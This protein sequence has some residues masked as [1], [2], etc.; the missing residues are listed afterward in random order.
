MVGT[1]EMAV[2]SPSARRSKLAGST[3]ANA[4]ASPAGTMP[5]RACARARAPS[6]SSI[7]ASHAW[8]EK[9]A[10]IASVA[11][12]GPSSSESSDEKA[13]CD[14]LMMPV[15]NPYE[16]G[17]VSR[18]GQ[19]NEARPNDK[20][21][22]RHHTT[23]VS[24]KV[25]RLQCRRYRDE[26]ALVCSVDCAANVR[27]EAC[28]NP[29]EFERYKQY[30]QALLCDQWAVLGGRQCQKCQKNPLFVPAR[31]RS[32]NQRSCRSSFH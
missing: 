18:M 19:S 1:P 32:S 15:N 30:A 9:T 11:K 29:L 25:P 23:P 21:P 26:S 3:L 14:A 16:P 27:R 7:A 17:M 22:R 10:R 6:T 4:S 5:S 20:P 12:S 13:I 2:A 31:R 28:T 8:S 24:A